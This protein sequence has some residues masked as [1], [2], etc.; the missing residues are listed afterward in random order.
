MRDFLPI[1]SL[2]TPLK[3]FFSPVDT[4]HQVCQYK[5][6][7]SPS[8]LASRP[9]GSHEALLFYV[10]FEFCLTRICS[11]INNNT[12]RTSSLNQL[13]CDDVTLTDLLVNPTSVLSEGLLSP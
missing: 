11:Q 1:V 3:H 9:A 12:A 13:T 6:Q 8:R 5:L 4:F 7:S 2:K 10:I